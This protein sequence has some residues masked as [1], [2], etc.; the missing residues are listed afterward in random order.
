M[1]KFKD[2]Q[3]AAIALIEDFRD[4]GTGR[5]GMAAQ[6]FGA[7]RDAFGVQ[8]IDEAERQPLELSDFTCLMLRAPDKLI[9]DGE[10]Q[11]Q[12]LLGNHTS[13]PSGNCRYLSNLA[14]GH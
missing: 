5:V 6:C 1:R 11:R 12:F 14:R 9:D 7:I 2:D 10:E 4:N 13:L 3:G 8:Q